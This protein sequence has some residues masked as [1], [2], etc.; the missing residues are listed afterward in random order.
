MKFDSFISSPVTATTAIKHW[1]RWSLVMSLLTLSIIIV[2]H[3]QAKRAYNTCAHTCARCEKITTGTSYPKAADSLSNQYTT[4]NEQATV[5]R[6]HLARKAE[7]AALA[8][9]L[10]KNAPGPVSLQSINV[11]AR[12]C[13]AL[14]HC[15]PTYTVHTLTQKL[16]HNHPNVHFQVT[17]LE[18]REDTL[19]VTVTALLTPP[20]TVK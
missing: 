17:H 13:T 15:P 12:E 8:Y 11:T 3:V 4:I 18:Q 10:L 20:T 19:L 2:L 14:F 7:L 1:W 9:D 16:A 6:N 5:V